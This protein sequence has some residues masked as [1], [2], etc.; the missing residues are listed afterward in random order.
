LKTL[1][2]VE[3]VVFACFTEEVFQAYSRTLEL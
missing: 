3:R 1:H 2:E